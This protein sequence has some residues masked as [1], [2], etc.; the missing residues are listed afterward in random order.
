V[1]KKIHILKPADLVSKQPVVNNYLHVRTDV[2]N[3]LSSKEAERAEKER[4][5][6]NC[7]KALGIS[8]SRI[9]IKHFSPTFDYKGL[10]IMLIIL[11]QPG[12]ESSSS[13]RRK[14]KQQVYDKNSILR[15]KMPHLFA[16]ELATS[17]NSCVQ[18]FWILL[19][20]QTSIYFLRHI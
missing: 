15:K 7:G 18:P 20:V 1:Q 13:L 19:F 5:I 8:V 10:D 4:I 11:E 14:L 2:A 6:S 9:Q 12:K 16:T 3:F 17:S